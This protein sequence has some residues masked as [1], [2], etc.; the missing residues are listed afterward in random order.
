MFKLKYYLSFLFDVLLEQHETPINPVLKLYLSQGQLKL[1]SSNAVYSYGNHYYNFRD[2]FS[3]MHLDQF[4]L[5][6]ILILGLGTGSILQILEQKFK[7]HAAFDAVE[8]DPVIVS[9]FEKYKHEISKNSCKIY[10]KD[11]LEFMN[12]NHKTYDL[13]CMDIFNDR[14]V[15]EQFETIDFLNSLKNSLTDRGIL[16]YNRINY[17]GMDQDKNELFFKLFEGVFPNAGIIK[18]DFNWMFVVKPGGLLN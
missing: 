5:K 13:I 16:I 10:L 11:A 1:V 18:L 14:T 6:D 9:V 4:D 17:N 3:I 15:P 8:I 12:S 7:I 2:S